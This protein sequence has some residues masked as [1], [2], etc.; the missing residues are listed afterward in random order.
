MSKPLFDLAAQ[1]AH[2][3]VDH[4]GL[5]VEVIA[6]DVLEQHRARDHLAGVAHEVGEQGELPRLQ[7]DLAARAAHHPGEQVDLEVRE[8]EARLAGAAAGPPRQ[9]F[10]PRQQLGE[11]EG[12][13]QIVVAAGPEP[14]HA[15]VHLGERTQDEHRRAPALAPQRLDQREAVEARQHAVDHEGIEAIVQRE[16]EPVGPVVDASSTTWPLSLRPFSR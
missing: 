2:V 10:E 14:F 8:A 11:G 12:L 5:R 7:G 6:P 3:D 16:R 15:V 9:R 13:G 4:V 1:P